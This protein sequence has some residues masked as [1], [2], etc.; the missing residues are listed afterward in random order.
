MKETKAPCPR[1]IKIVAVLLVLQAAGLMG[2]G[3]VHLVAT[4]AVPW[5]SADT[6]SSWIT[7]SPIDLVW[8][9]ERLLDIGEK[10]SPLVAILMPLGLMAFVSAL[11][12]RLRKRAA[13]TAAMAVQS[14]HLLVSLVIYFTTRPNYASLLMA[15]G[16]FMVLYLNYSE[17]ANAFRSH[18]SQPWEVQA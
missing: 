11:G 15:W 18:Q 4:Y 8:L 6:I 13:W 1:E 12:L 16:V 5:I 7:R 14:I 10:S 3:F 17:V 9:W 2:I